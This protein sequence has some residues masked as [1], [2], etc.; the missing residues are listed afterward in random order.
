[1]ESLNLF[2]NLPVEYMKFE[3]TVTVEMI[4]L[5]FMLFIKKQVSLSMHQT[6]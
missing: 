5:S 1:M 3:N 6:F 2:H 4:G